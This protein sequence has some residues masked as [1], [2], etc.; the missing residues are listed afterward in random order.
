[1]G[2]HPINLMI[3][4]ILEIIAL[5]AVGFW[6]W[7]RFDGFLQFILGVGLPLAMTVIWGVFAV[8]E[9]PSRSGKARV[10]ISGIL[11]LILEF[12]FF[13]IAVWSLFDLG[14]DKLSYILGGLIII[15]YLVSYDRISWLLSKKN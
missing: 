15:H 9:D 14:Y 7:K 2:S 8:P 3:R 1:M 13:T 10:P 4:F 5:L 6:G 12:S 11:R